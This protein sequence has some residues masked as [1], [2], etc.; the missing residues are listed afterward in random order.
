MRNPANLSV[1]PWKKYDGTLFEIKMFQS[2]TVIWYKNYDIFFPAGTRVNKHYIN[3]PAIESTKRC[4][5]DHQNPQRTKMGK[6]ASGRTR[7]HLSSC[8]HSFPFRNPG[9]GA[10][11]AQ[12]WLNSTHRCS[13]LATVASMYSVSLFCRLPIPCNILALLYYLTCFHFH[14][15]T[16]IPRQGHFQEALPDRW[17]DGPCLGSKRTPCTP[18]SQLTHTV[19]TNSDFLHCSPGW[20]QFVSFLSIT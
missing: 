10:T 4:R 13:A 1:S 2:V 8:S 7:S 3:K 17:V 6:P 16:S 12:S 19:L 18:L 20:A 15:H 14:F 9:N 11:D 5:I